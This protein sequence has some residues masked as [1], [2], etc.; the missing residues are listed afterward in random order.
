LRLAVFKRNTAIA[1]V[2]L[3]STAAGMMLQSMAAR[4]MMFLFGLLA[5]GATALGCGEGD[6]DDDEYFTNVGTAECASGRKWTGGNEESE[7]MRPGGN[8]IVCHRQEDEG[9]DYQV[10][11]TVYDSVNAAD[12][13]AG[14]ADA[15]ITITD[16]NG[17]V[18]TLRSNEAG[19]FFLRTNQGAIAVPYT[20]SLSYRG[21][22]RAMQDP[23]TDLNCANCHTTTGANAAPGRIVLP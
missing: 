12:D 15:E 11:G 4:A 5:L 10:A 8:C 6:E 18:T 22:T 20:A 2:W 19:N 14:V 21:D 7:L 23:Q 9:P 17:V 1:V 3:N 16:A 13:C